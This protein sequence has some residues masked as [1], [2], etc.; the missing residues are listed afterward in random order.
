MNLRNK[1]FKTRVNPMHG[2]L[3]DVSCEVQKE[4]MPQE[5]KREMQKVKG[6][7]TCVPYQLQRRYE[8]DEH[9]WTRRD[10]CL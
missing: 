2:N 8:L 3:K 10:C 5:A 1:G 7:K 9:S 4:Q 6:E